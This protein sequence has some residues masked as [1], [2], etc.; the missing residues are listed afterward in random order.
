[1]NKA[2]VGLWYIHISALTVAGTG[3]FARSINLPAYQ[4][5]AWRALFASLVLF[6]FIKLFKKT[7]K[8]SIQEWSWIIVLGMAT[9]FHWVTFF[10]AMQI[11]GVAVGMLSLFT[12]PVMIV[13][14]EPIINKTAFH[15][16]DLVAAF[17]VFG[18]I[19]LMIPELDLDNQ[20][21]QGVF[22]GVISAFVWSFRNIYFKKKLSH[23]PSDQSM[24]WQ[25][26]VVAI[27]LL[28]LSSPD[29]FEVSNNDWFLL[30]ALALFCT[31]LP[32]TLLLASMKT[33]SAKTSGLIACL[34]PVYGTIFAIFILSEAPNWQT[35]VGGVFIIGASVFES[36]SVINQSRA[37]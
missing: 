23:L 32:H 31:A 25:L 37:R 13:L 20:T 36:L 12:F 29:V 8:M 2:P 35:V 5:I 14:F 19:A 6:I 22:W 34:Q 10:H 16:K 27:L 9:C 7:Q 17:A 4:L 18:G 3:V 24:M 1:M 26:V 28:P 15:K 21:T 30:V 11:S 33:L